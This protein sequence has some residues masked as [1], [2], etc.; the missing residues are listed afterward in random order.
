MMW[1]AWN[2]LEGDLLSFFFKGVCRSCLL[3][4]G[5]VEISSKRCWFLFE[6]KKS[7]FL[8]NRPSLE[9]DLKGLIFSYLGSTL[10]NLY[11]SVVQQ[12]NV[13]LKTHLLL[14]LSLLL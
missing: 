9:T 14:T 12:L 1:A 3:G 10:L 8:L 11:L 7:L 4:D 6:G 13:I 5:D 2:S